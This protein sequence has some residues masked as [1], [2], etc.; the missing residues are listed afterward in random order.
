MRIYNTVLNLEEQNESDLLECRAGRKCRIL[1][2]PQ[3][4]SKF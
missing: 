1:P 3:T 4:K 2:S